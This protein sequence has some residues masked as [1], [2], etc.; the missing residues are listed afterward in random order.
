[1]RAGLILFFLQATMIQHID[2]TAK[3]SLPI[4]AAGGYAAV[5]HGKVVY[6]GGSTWEKGVKRFLRETHIFDARSNRW[7]NGAPLPV[8]LAYGASVQ[9][10]RGL[11]ILGG[12][13]G[14]TT[15]RQCWVLE[16]ADGT[17]KKCE[18]D[19]GDTI[20]GTAQA[21]GNEVAVFGGCPNLTELA[22]CSASVRVR[23]NAGRWENIGEMPQGRVANVASAA[24]NGSVYLFGGVSGGDGGR[25]DNHADAYRLELKSRQWR[26]CRPLPRAVRGMT[27]VAWDSRYIALA[28]GYVATQAEAQGKPT[29]FGFSGDVLLYDTVA[30]E[31]RQVG[32]LPLP[33]AGPVMVRL[34][35]GIVAIGGEERMRSRTAQ[36]LWGVKR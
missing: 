8:P 6:A 20:L 19:A 21:V 24:I 3:A 25:I 22:R 15:S 32:S 27:A 10:S 12:T 23:S 29:D 4:P 26:R 18:G 7:G 11:E 28:G 35:D 33:C 14:D 17:W 34:G 30:D 16:K 5:V 1:M 9:T 2:W 36:V 31:Y 13:D